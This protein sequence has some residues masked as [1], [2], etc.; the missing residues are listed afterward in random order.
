MLEISSRHGLWNDIDY[1]FL[2]VPTQDLIFYAPQASMALRLNRTDLPVEGGALPAILID[3]M[4]SRDVVTPAIAPANAFHLGVGLTRD[5][6]LACTY[7]HADAGVAMHASREILDSAIQHAF[8]RA[9]RTPSRIL[10]ASF[11]V[12]GEPTLQWEEFVRTV[13]VLRRAPADVER[14]FLSITTNAYYGDR[15]R[16]FVGEQFDTITV[17]I[18][19]P[20]EIH[21]RHRPTRAG[22]GSYR[23]VA[24]S[25]RYWIRNAPAR[26]AL[27][28]TV[29]SVSVG[30]LVDIVTHFVDQ[31]GT[32][33]T[34]AFEPLIQI[35]R[36][37]QASDVAA[38]DLEQFTDSFL[39]AREK[40]CSLGVRVT[41]SG[42]SIN[43]LIQRFCGAMTIPSF[44]VCIDGAVTA[45][46]RDQNAEAYGYGVVG[47]DG[48]VEIDRSRLKALETI[49]E[50]LPECHSC[51]AKW[52]CAGDC[53]DLRRA[54][55]S[56]CEFNR[57]LLYDDISRAF[58]RSK[59]GDGD[60]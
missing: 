49:N 21:D 35:G 23:Q 25:I 14:V 36:G 27:R 56:R 53:P 33:N 34:I 42:A 7:C 47:R 6:S 60:A 4:A 10:S 3:R 9:A 22:R 51:F 41:S 40:G 54:N 13:Q 32:S 31:F 20:A 37:E 1:W 17:S 44:A 58:A 26:L 38:P 43:R 8:A 2:A 16:A 46:H 50:P 28:A 45:C 18:D 59:G 5:C 24:D 12:G 30:S 48:L 57:A 11:A 29:S 39:A 52:H 15:K 19:G 55:W